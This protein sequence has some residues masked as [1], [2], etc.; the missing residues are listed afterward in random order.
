M[1]ACGRGDS[2]KPFRGKPMM[3]LSADRY[4]IPTGSGATLTWSSVNATACLASGNWN[5]PKALSGSESFASLKSDGVY[6]L[7]CRGDKGTMSRTVRLIVGGAPSGSPEI[8]M[9]A[10]FLT[11]DSGGTATLAWSVAGADSC[12]AEGA[13]HGARESHGTETTPPLRRSGIYRLACYGPHGSARD[14]VAITV[15]P[16]PRGE[17]GLDFPS[18]GGSQD[19]RFAFTGAALIP[20]YPA[21]YIWRVN[22]RRQAGYYTTFFWGPNGPFTGESYFGC[23]PYPDGNPKPTSRSHKWELSIDRDDLVVD[24][25]G[26]DTRVEYGS[27]KLQALRVQET[28]RGKVHEFFWNLPD[29]TKVIRGIM[30]RE[31][32]AIAPENPAL[33]FGDAPWA[34]GG[35]RLSGVLRGIQLYT[36]ALTLPDLL[37]ESKEP[38]ST[39]AGAASVWYV[40]RDPVPEDISDKSGRGHHPAWVGPA[41]AGRWPGP[42]N[43]P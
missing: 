4:R 39:S 10:D 43:G 3:T 12:G 27:W 5:G 23:H 7:S 24:A 31:Y 37:T 20:M 30:P 42:G 28:D 18:N 36:S 22:L 40:N 8:S 33:T 1:G 17:A 25:N 29:T 38:L 41:K 19:I 21:T 11:V 15:A 16:P 35:E 6:N 14:S 34:L 13:W 26:H 32:G 2:D 9:S